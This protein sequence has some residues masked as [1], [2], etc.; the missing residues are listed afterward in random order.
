MKGPR[1]IPLIALGLVLSACTDNTAPGNDREAELSPPEPPAEVASVGGAVEGVAAGLLLPQPMTE[2]DL[3]NVPDGADRCLFRFTR[4]GLPIFA[5][6][7]IGVLKLNGR[8]VPLEAAGDGGA[9]GDGRYAAG[10]VAVTMRPVG[11]A[12]EDGEPF[13]AELVLRLPDSD[14][15]RGYHGFSECDLAGP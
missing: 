13:V 6:G 11:D 2:P 12:A 8:L 7:A 15:E 4:V 1:F 3:S 5:Y 14:H 10:G 9:M